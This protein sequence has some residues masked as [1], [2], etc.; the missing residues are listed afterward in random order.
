LAAANKFKANSL[1]VR[2][3][4]QQRKELEAEREALIVTLQT[5]LAQVKT[6]RGLLPICA[7]C[8]KIRDDDG[9]WQDVAVYVRDHTEAWSSVT[10]FAPIV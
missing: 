4:S 9:Y 6:L 2:N 3:I 8:K 10:V 1:I 7:N 5:T